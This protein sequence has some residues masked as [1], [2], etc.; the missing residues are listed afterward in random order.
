MGNKTLKYPGEGGWVLLKCV[1]DGEVAALLGG[2][3]NVL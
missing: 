3:V 1:M 2:N